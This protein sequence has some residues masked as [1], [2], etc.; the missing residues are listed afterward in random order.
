MTHERL[1]DAGRRRLRPF[2]GPRAV[3][4]ALG[5]NRARRRP[6]SALAI[7]VFIAVACSIAGCGGQKRHPVAPA[8]KLTIYVTGPVAKSDTRQ[9]HDVVD[10]ERLALS[11]TAGRVGSF[12]INLVSLDGSSPPAQ[13]SST[14]QLTEDDRLVAADPTAIADLTNTMPGFPSRSSE[15]LDKAGVLQIAV[16]EAPSTASEPPSA[17]I[18]L[19]AG[20]GPT[21]AAEASSE[22]QLMRGQRIRRLLVVT[23]GTAY[24]RGVAH[25]LIH[26]AESSQLKPIG[27]RTATPKTEP[28]LIK[29]IKAAKPDGV[30]FGGLASTS[31]VEFWNRVA[32]IDPRVKLFGPRALDNDQFAAA[33]ELPAQQRTFLDEPGQA[34]AELSPAGQNFIADF[35]ATYGHA[36]APAAFFG[37][38]ATQ[39]VL[40]AIHLS[41]RQARHRAAGTFFHLR[42]VPSV[43]G[44]YSIDSAGTATLVPS[45]IFSTVKDGRRVLDQIVI[46]HR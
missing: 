28:K 26:A 27:V 5:V 4:E 17:E 3:P 40:E 11:Q 7:F 31:A 33:I 25:S 41:G 44:T 22:L 30:F 46:A 6:A 9:T 45:F 14:E 2:A 23:D 43:L 13:K 10:A 34:L 16:G 29:E 36:P 19:L 21:E 15:A 8:P 24:G 1:E 35:T 18:H 20:F 37:Y 32:T 12:R 39:A 38:A 42:N